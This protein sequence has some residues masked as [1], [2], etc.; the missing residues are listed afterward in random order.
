MG[1]QSLSPE[2]QPESS[3]GYPPRYHGIQLL[4]HIARTVVLEERVLRNLAL[5]ET[6]TSLRP[7]YAPPSAAG[8]E[9]PT[10]WLWQHEA[11]DCFVDDNGYMYYFNNQTGES[12]WNPP[13]ELQELFGLDSYLQPEAD[14]NPLLDEDDH[15]VHESIADDTSPETMIES[16]IKNAES[17]RLI[18][19]EETNAIVDSSSSMKAMLEKL[20]PTEVL[21][22]F[23]S[24]TQ[25]NYQLLEDRNQESVAVLQEL[26]DGVYNKENLIMVSWAYKFH[27]FRGDPLHF[28]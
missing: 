26:S 28:K 6:R 4:R 23:A 19:D 25:K 14:L 24:K 5:K 13:P 3:A 12:S 16:K 18:W 7:E 15:R 1:N 21:T 8:D 10:N 27:L 17:K 22:S 9:H 20:D 11:W 2:S